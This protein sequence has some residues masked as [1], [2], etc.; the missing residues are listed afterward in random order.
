M[1]RGF[2]ATIVLEGE[3][4][5]PFRAPERMRQAFRR[6]WRKY[7]VDECPAC[8]IARIR[9]ERLEN[10]RIDADLLQA[11]HVWEADRK[12]RLLEIERA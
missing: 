5:T 10:L 2:S 6:L 8:R 7:I 4:C 11:M 9:E 3:L 1:L 12:S